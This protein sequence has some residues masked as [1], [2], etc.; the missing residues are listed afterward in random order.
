MRSI[1]GRM[2]TQLELA[3]VPPEAAPH[4]ETFLREVAWRLLGGVAE[5]AVHPEPTDTLQSAAWKRAAAYLEARVQTST[6]ISAAT[7]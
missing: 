3:R 7:P 6:C 1:H 2:L 5:L 4:V